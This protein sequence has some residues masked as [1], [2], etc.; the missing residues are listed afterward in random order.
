MADKP[1][2][3]IA[4]KPP[5]RPFEPGNNANPHGRP[6]GSRNKLGED[7]IHALAEDFKEHGVAAIASMRQ[8][9]PN[10]YVKVVASLLPKHVEIKDVTLDELER[11]ELAAL[12]DA[13][14]TARL[15]READREGALH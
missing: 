8:D 15:A 9:K 14:R 13:V 5:G 12:L 7:F 4:K 11:D 2:D 3:K 10:E 1:A 6:K